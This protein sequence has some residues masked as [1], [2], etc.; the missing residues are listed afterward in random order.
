MYLWRKTEKIIEA[1][2]KQYQEQMK[3][4][5][6]QERSMKKSN[7]KSSVRTPKFKK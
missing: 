1:E 5:A 7:S 2:N 4:T 6:A 3:Q